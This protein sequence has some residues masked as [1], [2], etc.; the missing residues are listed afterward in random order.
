VFIALGS[1]LGDREWNLRRAVHEISRFVRLVRIS[2]IH[3]TAPVDAPAGSRDF[4]NMMAVG[5]T[6]R[7]PFE[8][9][10]ALLDVE[11]R[12]GRVR[13]G[14]R[15]APRVIDLDLIFFGARRIRTRELTVPHPR[16]GEREF[17]LAPLREISVYRI[18]R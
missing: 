1:N 5:R 14:A 7:T 3:E 11:S 12:L 2:S 17:V 16:Y 15:N 10:R 6:T 13:T 18:R 4:L 8:L 9:M